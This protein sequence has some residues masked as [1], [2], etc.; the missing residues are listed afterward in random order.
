[1]AVIDKCLRPRSMT[2]SVLGNGMFVVKTFEYVINNIDA[3]CGPRRVND[4]CEADKG[5]WPFW[6]AAQRSHQTQML[7]QLSIIWQTAWCCKERKP[8]MVLQLRH[9]ERDGISNFRHLDYLFNG[10]SRRWSKKTLKLWWPVTGGF[11]SQRS[12]TRKMFPFN[13]VITILVQPPTKHV[14]FLIYIVR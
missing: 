5:R 13:D 12:V 14:P 10:L 6:D 3:A 8:F 2:I 4:R 9:N 11:P 7:H 1:M